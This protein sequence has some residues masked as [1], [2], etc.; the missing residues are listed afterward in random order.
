MFG[1]KIVNK[2]DFETIK[3]EYENT[4]VILAEKVAVI[5]SLESEIKTLKD[6]L[7][8]FEKTKAQTRKKNAEKVLL[9][10]DVAETPLEVEKPKRRKIVKK[11]PAQSE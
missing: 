1:L 4:Q 5:R 8:K 3:R 10:T 9:L 11:T 2:K 6:K 7:A